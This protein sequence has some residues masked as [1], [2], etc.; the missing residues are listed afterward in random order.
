MPAFTKLQKVV[1][2]LGAFSGAAIYYINQSEDRTALASWTT[3]YIPSV[4]WDNNWD[5]RS[6]HNLVHPKKL[7]N[8]AHSE[9][10]I[11]KQ[12]EMK[13]PKA[14]RHIILI[15]HGQYNTD[16]ETDKERVL[17]DLGRMQ[18]LSTGERLKE[19]GFPFTDMVKSTMS[20]AQETGTLISKALPSVPVEN[21]DLLREGAP[22]PPEPP[23]GDWKPE[24]HFFTD[25]ARIEAAFREY[26]YRA[27]HSQDENS[28]T[29]LVCH[30]NVIRYFVCRALQFPAE[31]WLRISLNHGSITW[32]SITPS[33]RV[34]L[35]CLGDTGHMSP[36][37][38]TSR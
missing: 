10:E 25:G 14:T 6:P 36:A 20:R 27:S 31:G 13:K 29:I 17:T 2:S 7:N 19:L 33:G 21:S 37:M 1:L 15:R 32:M 4:E 34:I 18:A 35:R 28:Y 26:F 22:V 38:I 16:G 12:L 23:I 3:N 24:P 5:R 9:N 11:N 8:S 30:A